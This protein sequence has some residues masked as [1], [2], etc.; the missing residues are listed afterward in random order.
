[1]SENKIIVLPEV[2][3]PTA[4]TIRQWQDQRVVTLADVDRV[5][6]RPEGTARKRFNDNKHRFV[7]N[8]DYYELNQASEIRTLDLD[9]PQGGTPDKVI[10]LTE[11]GYLMLVKSFRDDLAWQVQRALVNAYFR[12]KAAPSPWLSSADPVALLR[13]TRLTLKQIPQLEPTIRQMY[14]ALGLDWPETAVQRSS[15]Q[16][17]VANDALGVLWKACQAHHDRIFGWNDSVT[18]PSNCIGWLRSQDLILEP[19][20]VESVLS[21]QGFA[22]PRSI[23]RIWRDHGILLSD[24]DGTHMLQRVSYRGHRVR[25]VVIHRFALPD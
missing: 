8:E 5:H 2:V 14:Q 1:M 19:R 12:A 17:S 16:E 23:Y 4:L 18:W 21:M 20:W 25:M 15:F 6:R 24:S 10:L 7:L 9:R 3:P 22:H 13:E 11:S